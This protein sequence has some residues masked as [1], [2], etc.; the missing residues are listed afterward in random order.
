MGYP[1]VF[2]YIAACWAIVAGTVALFGPRSGQAVL[3]ELQETETPAT[4]R[5][6]REP[7]RERVSPA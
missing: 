6:T 2:A 5:F 1:W 3:E 4:G 7:A